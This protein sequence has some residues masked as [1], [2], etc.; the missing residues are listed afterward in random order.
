MLVNG[1]PI[2]QT[3]LT[4][5]GGPQQAEGEEGEEDTKYRLDVQTEDYRT[6]LA[7]DGVDFLWIYG[8]VLCN[9][10][11]IDTASLTRALRFEVSGP[12]SDWIYLSPPEMSGG[13]KS[14]AIQASP[15]TE[16]AELA[17]GN[18]TVTVS[19]Q[20]EGRT[21]SAPV[22]ITL[23]DQDLELVIEEVLA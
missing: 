15:P 12:N 19:G 22:S 3:V 5:S 21:F 2:A 13:F 17:P 16:E 10:P 6:E 18:P 7:A 1:I 20:I 9:K 14:V 23:H 4:Q 8:Q 11:E